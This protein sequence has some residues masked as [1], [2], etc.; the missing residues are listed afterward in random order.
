MFSQTLKTTNRNALLFLA[1]LTAASA[2]TAM[3]SN[4]ANAAQLLMFVDQDCTA[5]EDFL[6]EIAPLYQRAAISNDLPL[7]VVDLDDR[8]SMRKLRRATREGRIDPIWRAMTFV[9]WDQGREVAR[10]NG[11]PNSDR[12]IRSVTHLASQHGLTQDWHV[13]PDLTNRHSI[14]YKYPIDRSKTRKTRGE[15]GVPISVR[16]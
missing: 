5:C 11:Y 8:Q 6:D 9:L 3:A 13:D 14:D 16:W 10:L 15:H 12:F 1:A 4:A 7:V 2:L